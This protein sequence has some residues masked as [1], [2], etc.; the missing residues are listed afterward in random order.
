MA[1]SLKHTFTSPK[2]DGPDTTLVQPSNWNAEHTITMATGRLLGRTSASAGIAEEISAGSNMSLVSGVLNLASSV[3][4]T[5]LTASGALQGST[6]TLTSATASVEKNDTAGYLMLTSGTNATD[7]ANVTLYGSTH[8]TL[9][10]QAVLEGDTIIFRSVSANTNRATLNSSGLSVTGTLTTTGNASV[11][12]SFDASTTIAAGTAFRGNGADSA[13]APSYAFTGDIDTGMFRPS[14][15]KL[16]FSTDGVGRVYIDDA[17]LVGVANTIPL[18]RVHVVSGSEPGVISST[19]TTVTAV[20]TTNPR[21][22]GNTNS[23]TNTG[24]VVFESRSNVSTLQRFHFSFCNPNGVVGSISTSGSAT[25]FNT[26]SDYRLKTNVIPVAD[27]SARVLALNPVNFKWIADPAGPAVD[28]FLAHEA[29]AVVPQA[30]TGTKDEVNE[31]GAPAYQGI[32]Q[33]KLV[34]LLT[35]ALREALAEITALKVRVAA[36]EL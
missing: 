30:V 1:I 13:A 32:D 34:P 21:F 19:G 29:Q 12:G 7:G 25:G 36:L 9:A 24:S 10:N 28:G 4:I 5:A 11:T 16:G 26:S 6:L 23:T 2:S 15:G 22:F 14:A 3:S 20:D 31:A 8:A 27:A 18:G 35:A 33:S 17:G